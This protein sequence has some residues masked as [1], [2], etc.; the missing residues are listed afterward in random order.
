MK[1]VQVLLGLDLWNIRTSQ[2]RKHD[3]FHDLINWSIV[4]RHSTINE[5]T[6]NEQH[7]F[8]CERLSRHFVSC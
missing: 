5:H 7:K 2:S 1:I 3:T 4:D 8:S 6:S